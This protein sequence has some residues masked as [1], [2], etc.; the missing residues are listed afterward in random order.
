MV[1]IHFLD[2]LSRIMERECLKVHRSYKWRPIETIASKDRE[3]AFFYAPL[4]SGVS[5]LVK[6]ITK[7]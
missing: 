7:Q 1:S 2:G 5:Q 4:Q 3:T 6:A